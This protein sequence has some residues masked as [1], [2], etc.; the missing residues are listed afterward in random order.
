MSSQYPPIH[1]RSQP[2]YTYSRLNMLWDRYP[3]YHERSTFAK[4]EQL[5]EKHDSYR[6]DFEEVREEYLEN[7]YEQFLI[8]LSWAD[9]SYR[10]ATKELME[11]LDTS[12]TNPYTEAFMAQF[13]DLDTDRKAYF[14]FPESY[15]SQFLVITEVCKRAELVQP[16]RNFFPDEEKVHY[17]AVFDKANIDDVLLMFHLVYSNVSREYFGGYSLYGYSFPWYQSHLWE[18]GVRLLY[19]NYH[20]PLTEEYFLKEL[21]S[22]IEK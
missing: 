1:E 12:V 9:L 16:V 8:Q 5:L 21:V 3:Q 7:R 20:Q 2:S 17:L 22:Q 6:E 11:S 15:V 10:Y 4:I 18:N 19:W 14:L 13:T